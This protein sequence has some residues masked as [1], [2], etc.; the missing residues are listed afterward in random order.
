MLPLTDEYRRKLT[1]VGYT[2]FAN[3]ELGSTFYLM[4][5]DI[6][7]AEMLF[8]YSALENYRGIINGT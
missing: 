4:P 6:P 5:Q 2:N 8:G 3:L 1:Q 7:M